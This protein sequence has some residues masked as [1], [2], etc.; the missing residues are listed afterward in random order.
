MLICLLCCCKNLLQEVARDA[1]HT[2]VAVTGRAL[3]HLEKRDA[4]GTAG[5]CDLTPKKLMMSVMWSAL[6]S[7]SEVLPQKPTRLALCRT[8]YLLVADREEVLLP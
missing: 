5:A 1:D 7:H 3:N 4:R 8:A 6:F 2:T